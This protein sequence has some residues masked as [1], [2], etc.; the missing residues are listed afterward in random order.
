QPDLIA[1]AGFM[2]ILGDDF[3]NRYQGK[4]INVHPSLLP[5]FPGLHTH[6]RALQE[7]VKIH[8][9]TVH[10]V[11]AQ[12]DCGPII[13]Q[14]AV[15]VL[16]D[17]TEQ[18]LAARVLRQ[19]HLI[20]PEAVRWFMERRLRISESAVDVSSAVFDGSVLYSPGL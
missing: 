12:M 2:R 18:T 14:A 11:T 5:A 1:L 16:P 19:E 20:Y 13:V 15:Q 8:G 4:L 6:R 17:D 7:G 3:A 9:C 10:F